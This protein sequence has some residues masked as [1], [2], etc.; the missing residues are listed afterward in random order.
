M[1]K[2]SLLASRQFTAINVVTVAFYGAL[3][4]AGYLLVLQW[5]AYACPAERDQR[6]TD[7]AHRREHQEDQRRT[8]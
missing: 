2:L 3:A 8:G 4:A 5:L 7:A 1:L 6:C